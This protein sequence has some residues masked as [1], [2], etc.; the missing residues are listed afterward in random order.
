MAAAFDQQ[1]LTA[2]VFL[3]PDLTV[4]GGVNAMTMAPLGDTNNPVPSQ[5]S[6]A[7]LMTEVRHCINLDRVTRPQGTTTFK[8]VK[9]T[10]L[11]L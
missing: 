11:S 1:S 5:V 10:T 3:N 7:L 2:Q 9:G 6:G 8:G 4:G